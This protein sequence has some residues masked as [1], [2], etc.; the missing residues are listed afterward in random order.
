MKKLISVSLAISLVLGVGNNIGVSEPLRVEASPVTKPLTAS[1]GSKFIDFK[2]GEYWSEPMEWMIGKGIIG[3]NAVKNPKSGV[4]EQWLNPR[5]YLTEAQFLAILYRYTSPVE[6]KTFIPVDV[7]YWASVPYQLAERDFL[8]TNATLGKLK[9]ANQPITRGKMAQLLASKHFNKLVSEQDGVRFMYE[10]ELSSGYESKDGDYPKTNASFG[11]K[12]KLQRA[13]I[14]AFIQRYDAFLANPPTVAITQPADILESIKV[15]LYGKEIKGGV[16]KHGEVFLPLKATF[17]AMGARVINDDGKIEVWQADG[18]GR[19]V[20]ELNS[21][22]V[23][24]GGLV[25]DLDA[26]VQTIQNDIMMPYKFG[27]AFGAKAVWNPAKK[28]VRLVAESEVVLPDALPWIPSGPIV[29]L[30]GKHEYGSHN[31]TEYDMIMK[32]AKDAINNFKWHPRTKLALDAYL[33]GERFDGDYNNRSSMN[34]ALH[35]MHFTLDPLFKA[36]VSKEMAAKAFMADEI[37]KGLMKGA[38]DPGDGSPRSAY[39]S[40]VRGLQDCDPQAEIMNLVFDIM[41]FNTMILASSA[42]AEGY[43]QINGSWF[44][45]GFSLAENGTDLSTG[46]RFWSWPTSG[47]Y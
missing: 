45:S 32:I 5:D 12:D 29:T 1:I 43:A 23:I 2:A 10:A 3:G 15:T 24:F 37:S 28:T 40:L 46:I 19:L 42:H 6:L 30:Y 41:G 17:E 7:K 21:K 16:I 36:G 33:N 31:Q 47:K 14:S 9:A 4:T 34:M 18:N 25:T 39:D 26:P 35:G 27:G 20:A 44:S 8:P 38:Y 13:H 22:S 11:P